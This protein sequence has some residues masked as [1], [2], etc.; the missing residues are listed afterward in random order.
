MPHSST[1]SPQLRTRRKQPKARRASAGRQG[2]PLGRTRLV[3]NVLMVLAVILDLVA[4]EVRTV[5][6][7]AMSYITPDA[8]AQAV[9]DLIRL[10]WAICHALRA[11]LGLWSRGS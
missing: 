6:L 11:L 5:L 8:L 7:I 1:G 3:L 4:P 10:G 2:K 9:V